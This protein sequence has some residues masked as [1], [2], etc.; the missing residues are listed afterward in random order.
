MN[1]FGIIG[2]VALV[3]AIA[4]IIIQVTY[5]ERGFYLT[6]AGL[7]LS[8]FRQVTKPKRRRR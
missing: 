4:G 1:K 8:I 7:L 5:D 2:L 6:L 3:M